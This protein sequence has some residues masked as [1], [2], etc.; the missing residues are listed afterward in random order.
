MEA[1]VTAPVRRGIRGQCSTHTGYWMES[2]ERVIDGE[3]V[4]GMSRSWRWEGG[5]R[6]EEEREGERETV[7][8]RA[9]ER[10]W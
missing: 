5:R 8:K 6:G 1:G 9:K 10:Q 7:V 4:R 3:S 2:V